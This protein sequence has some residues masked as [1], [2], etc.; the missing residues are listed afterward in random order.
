MYMSLINSEN[1]FWKTCFFSLLDV[2]ISI[3]LKNQE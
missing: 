2:D 3:W 1:V